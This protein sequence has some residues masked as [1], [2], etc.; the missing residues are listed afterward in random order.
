M[1]DNDNK[2]KLNELNLD[3][4][5]DN[6]YGA[7]EV[8]KRHTLNEIREKFLKLVM[9][10]RG[11]CRL[12]KPWEVLTMLSGEIPW[13]FCLG[14]IISVLIVCIEQKDRTPTTVVR[15]RSLCVAP[16]SAYMC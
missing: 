4:F 3:K 5:T 8:R 9:E 15:V 7:N 6:M 10:K 14:L 13:T 1:E 12:S 16:F 11:L 2:R